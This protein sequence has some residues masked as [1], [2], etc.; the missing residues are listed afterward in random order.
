M[1]HAVVSHAKVLVRYSISFLKRDKFS[2]HYLVKNMGSH[3]LGPRL[4]SRDPAEAFL[5]G[6]NKENHSYCCQNANYIDINVNL[7]A[8]FFLTA[9]HHSTTVRS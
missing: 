6:V 9:F 8:S 1:G 4:E 7:A 5:K 3:F 2:P